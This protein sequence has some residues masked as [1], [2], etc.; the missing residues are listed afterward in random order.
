MTMVYFGIAM[1]QQASSSPIMEGT[2]YGIK[3]LLKSSSRVLYE[4]VRFSVCPFFV[5]DKTTTTTTTIDI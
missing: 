4:T 2:M 5:R 3:N 1:R